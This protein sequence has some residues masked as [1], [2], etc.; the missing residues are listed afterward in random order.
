MNPR[1]LPNGTVLFLG[2]SYEGA[3]TADARGRTEP[4][5][6]TYAALKQAG[7]WYFSGSG[8]VPQAAGWGAVEKW[9]EREGRKLEWVKIV[10]ELTDVYP[11]PLP[12][13]PVAELGYDVASAEA[14][15]GRRGL[16][17]SGPHAPEREELKWSDDR[18]YGTGPSP[19]AELESDPRDIPPGY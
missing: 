6:Y 13:S 18:T 17:D 11:V 7:V 16:L 5:V 8:R 4:K 1:A 9:L 10:S 12:T 14:K 2:I 15:Q 3:R 19:V